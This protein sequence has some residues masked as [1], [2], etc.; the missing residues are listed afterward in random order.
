MR[1]TIPR[2]L[3]LLVAVGVLAAVAVT[4]VQLVGL[5][6]SLIEERRAAIRA[7]VE[8]AITMVRHFAAEAAAGRMTDAEAQERAKEALRAMRYGKGDY[9]YAQRYDGVTMVNGG[10]PQNEGRNRLG[11]VDANGV[12]ITEGQ[13]RAAQRGGDY[14]AY[15]FP[16]AGQDQPVP[17]LTYT[18]PVERWNWAVGTGVY[19]D[20]VDAVFRAHMLNALGWSAGL[21][22]L[23]GLCAWPVIRGITRPLRLMTLAMG[24]LAAGNT[25]VSVPG[26]GRRDEIGDMARAV[27]V[28]K[29]SMIEAERLRLDQERQ[30]AEAAAAQRMALHRLAEEFEQRVGGVV[31]AVGAAAAELEA[32][33]RSMSATTELTNQRTEAASAAVAKT[34]GNVETVASA[35]EQLASSIQEISRQVAH[36]ATVAG[37]ATRDAQRTN[38]VVET[39]VDCAQK[40][41][42]VVRL[43]GDIAGQTNLLALNATIEAARAGEAG[44]G[45]AVVASEVK[46]LAAQTAKATEEIGQQIAAIQQ[47]SGQAAEAIRGIAVTIGEIDSISSAIAAAVEEQGAA[48]REIARN[49]LEASQSTQEVGSNVNSVIEAAAESGAASGQVLQ[50]ASELTRH[51]DQLAGQVTTFLAEVRAA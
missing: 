9:F 17:K 37:Q 5:R 28:F 32:T 19:M 39:L 12:R 23:V 7:E 41:G 11:S 20:D 24:E 29:D 18:A 3:G 45:F 4:A 25:S 21:L 1:L 15:S 42:E 14:L 36:A 13:I 16:R 51:A 6:R 2:R 46:Q 34:S 40:I 43:I 30:K 35:S 50:A 8:T 44:K 48:T 33:A 27:T 47:A 38:A 10:Q 31:R 22:L 26:E 49:V